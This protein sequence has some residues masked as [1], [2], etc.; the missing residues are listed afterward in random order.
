MHKHTHA[1]CIEGESHK[2]APTDV[3]VH[4][5]ACASVLEC[6]DEVCLSRMRV[7]IFLHLHVSFVIYWIQNYL[8]R[9]KFK[10]TSIR[11]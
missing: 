6:V 2:H 10:H 9:E 5:C 7:Y 4:T 3:H 11:Q 8:G 1:D